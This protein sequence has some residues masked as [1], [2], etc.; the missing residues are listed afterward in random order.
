MAAVLACGD[1]A[2]L[3]HQ[4]AATLQELL[5]ARG[6]SIHVTVPRRASVARAAIRAHRSPCLAPQDRTEI[7]GVPCTSVPA[8]LLGLAATAPPN[9]LESACN[10]AEIRGL[11]DMR[12][13]NALLHRRRAHPGAARL[14]LALAVDGLGSDRTKS[15][16]EARFLELVRRAGLPLSAVNEWMAITGEEMQCDFVWHRHRVIAET[17]GWDTH[18]TRRA[19]VA[20]HRRDQLLRL[21][22]WDV[23]RF[24]SDDVDGRSEHVLD[25]LRAAIDE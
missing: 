6:G 17:D 24:T 22:G 19:F 25:V 10:K 20:D 1:G 3:S 13:V 4:S 23:I 12:A 16:L 11:L 8:M 18:R 5:S 21:A 2:L 14:R 15:P 9:V 7:D